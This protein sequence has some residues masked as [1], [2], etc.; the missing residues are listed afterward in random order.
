MK[1]LKRSKE[2]F[3][4]TQKRNMMKQTAVKMNMKIL[5]SVNMYMKAMMILL[6]IN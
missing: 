6:I 4:E 3:S 5:I 1:N 2:E